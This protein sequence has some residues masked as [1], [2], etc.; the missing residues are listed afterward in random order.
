MQAE[1]RGERCRGTEMFG[2]GRCRGRGTFGM[3]RLRFL[4]TRATGGGFEG[5]TESS[6]A[7]TASAWR[8]AG[9][10]VGLHFK[11]ANTLPTHRG[12]W[13]AAHMTLGRV[14]ECLRRCEDGAA[15][16]RMGSKESPS[17]WDL[18]WLRQCATGE[19][20]AER[21]MTFGLKGNI[22]ERFLMLRKRHLS[23]ASVPQRLG[24]FCQI[25]LFQFSLHAV[26]AAVC[27]LVA[28]CAEA[29]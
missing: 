9:C 13:C 23:S 12:S 29:S 16:G 25:I 5:V 20:G 15:V 21:G 1:S 22:V 28:T 4:G 7:C 6:A 26:V 27:E 24:E 11:A 2:R 10:K 18:L 3:K 19:D 17:E 8:T 14:T